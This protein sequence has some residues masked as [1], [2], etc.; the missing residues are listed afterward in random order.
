MKLIKQTLKGDRQIKDGIHEFVIE[1]V[2][3][4]RI[5]VAETDN[6]LTLTKINSGKNQMTI[7][8]QYGNQVE[9]T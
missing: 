4:S 8:P 5:R 6:G 1:Q 7:R 9:I 2:N 3:G